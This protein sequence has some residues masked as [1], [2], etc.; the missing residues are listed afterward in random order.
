VASTILIS[1]L[2]SI[3]VIPCTLILLG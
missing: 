2:L 1:T 3:I